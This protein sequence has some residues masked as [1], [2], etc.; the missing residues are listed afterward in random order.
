MG[1]F[2]RGTHARRV[3]D[4]WQEQVVTRPAASNIP[5]RGNDFAAG[6]LVTWSVTDA[7]QMRLSA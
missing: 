4:K 7:R 6:R 1:I 3:R 2:R 5:L